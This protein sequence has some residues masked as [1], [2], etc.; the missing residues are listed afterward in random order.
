MIWLDNSRIIAVFA[1]ILLHVSSGIVLGKEVG[2]YEWW[3]G[4]IYDSAV[5][6]CVPVFVMISGALLLS[7][8]KNE[9]LKTFYLKRT[10]K[11]LT[12][13]FFWSMLFITL[14]ILEG[15]VTGSKLTYS[16]ILERILSGKPHYHMWYIYMI[17]FLYIITPALRKI[18]LNS[19]QREL[20]LFSAIGFIISTLNY[21]HEIFYNTKDRIFITWFLD[22]IPYFLMGLYIK[23]DMNPPKIITIFL[24]LTISIILTAIGCFYLSK[25]HGLDIGLYFYG[26]VSI[27]VIPM[28]I[29]IMYLFKSLNRSLL[30]TKRTRE[31]SNLTFGIYLFHPLILG[32][33]Q[34]KKFGAINFEPSISIPTITVFVFILSILVTFTMSKTPILKRLI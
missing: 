27:T 26:Y 8:E 30:N 20:L 24:T 22:Y 23:R 10:S 17:V 14:A 4:N 18:A 31:L 13:A 15:L 3:I 1:V 12:P 5:R 29:S 9:N 25:K 21:A 28:S 2:S 32:A 6:W 33:L 16:D 19:T 34:Y 7:E 11:I